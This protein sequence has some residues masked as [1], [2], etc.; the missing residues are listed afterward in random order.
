MA[1]DK[2]NKTAIHC[3]LASE[4]AHKTALYCRTA[5]RDDFAIKNQSDRLSVFASANGYK[6]QGFYIDNGESG[7]TLCRPGLQ[8]M[9]LDIESGVIDVVI[10]KDL[11]RLCRNYLELDKLINLMTANEVR[12]ISVAEGGAVNGTDGSYTEVER[13]LRLLIER[14]EKA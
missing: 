4:P 14:Y 7:S 5:V 8:D 10:V 3:Q 13:L 12:L 1:G 11:A 2:E 9:I 6:N